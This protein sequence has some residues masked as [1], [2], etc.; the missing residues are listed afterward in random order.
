VCHFDPVAWSPS[1][2]EQDIASDPRIWHR[3][4]LFII[5]I[6]PRIG[7]P[8]CDRAIKHLSDQSNRIDLIASDG[9]GQLLLVAA[10]ASRPSRGVDT[11]RQRVEDDPATPDG[12]DEIVLADEVIAILHRLN[13]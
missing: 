4:P 11:V 9:A 3:P 1:Q 12:R 2:A 6:S 7:H 8:S 5:L 13:Q 10:I